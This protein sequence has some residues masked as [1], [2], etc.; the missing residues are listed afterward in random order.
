MSIGAGRRRDRTAGISSVPDR[1]KVCFLRQRVKNKPDTHLA[2]PLPA[3]A[4][5]A[6]DIFS[7][8]FCFLFLKVQGIYFYIFQVL[9]ADIMIAQAFTAAAS[10]SR[11]PNSSFST[12]TLCQHDGQSAAAF[13]LYVSMSSNVQNDGRTAAP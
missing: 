10:F 3:P 1:I 12:Q 2:I 4:G 6:R 9:T 7:P 8:L 11:R 13:A 5:P